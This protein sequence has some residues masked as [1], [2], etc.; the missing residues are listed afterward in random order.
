MTDKIVGKAI[1]IELVP[2]TT[3]EA[4]QNVVTQILVTPEGFDESANYVPMAVHSRTVS[5]WSPR[6]QWRISLSRVNNKELFGTPIAQTTA[7]EKA[8]EMVAQIESVIKRQIAYEMELRK[9]PIVAE[10]STIDLAEV[11][12][13]KT[14]SA[15]LR[16]IQKARVALNFP[17]KVL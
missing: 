1:Y 16:R 13:W 17:E 9:T 6:K 15:L 11:K 10:V 8:V 12:D 7:Q 3:K 4:G 2:K 5:D 14:P